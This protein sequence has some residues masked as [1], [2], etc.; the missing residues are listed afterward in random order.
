MRH[1]NL[2]VEITPFAEMLAVQRA[3]LV[4]RPAR[5]SQAGS[6]QRRSV[7][8]ARLLQLIV[9]CTYAVELQYFAFYSKY[10]NRALLVSADC[11]KASCAIYAMAT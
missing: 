7:R 11:A 10:S 5:R 1:G 8:P 6:R 4:Q 3:A 2:A 9:G